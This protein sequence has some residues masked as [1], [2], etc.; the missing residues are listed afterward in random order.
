MNENLILNICELW[1]D[2]FFPSYL[3]ASE[4]ISVIPIRF[5]WKQNKVN[6]NSLSLVA[7]CTSFAKSEAAVSVPSHSKDVSRS[8]SFSTETSE[9]SLL[10]NSGC[11]LFQNV[12]TYSFTLRQLQ[13]M[14][15]DSSNRITLS[16]GLFGKDSIDL[17]NDTA[18]FSGHNP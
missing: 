2:R 3:S 5:G 6:H 15:L 9:N 10:L 18:Q 4:T 8:K 1:P 13:K 14:R 12:T 16:S 11:C 17:P 7:A